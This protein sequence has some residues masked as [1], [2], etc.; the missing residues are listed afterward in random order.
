MMP[1]AK[2]KIE[3]RFERGTIA[4]VWKIRRDVYEEDITYDGIL[5]RIQ[6]QNH[7]DT[8][9]L[10]IVISE[11]IASKK[12]AKKEKI[13]ELK[14]QHQSIYEE[15]RL[16]R[17]MITDIVEDTIMTVDQVAD[18]LSCTTPTVIRYIKEEGL[19]A[20]KRGQWNMRESSVLQWFTSETGA[21]LADKLQRRAAG[22]KT[23]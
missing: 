9:R 20:V 18:M 12:R 19:P 4:K 2:K 15:Q 11:D 22:R 6:K 17:E 16:F 3:A 1:E 10:A 14:K 23:S 5:K 7:V 13:E 21:K 8:Y